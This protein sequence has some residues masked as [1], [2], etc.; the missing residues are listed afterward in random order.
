MFFEAVVLSV[1]IKTK[2]L[3]FVKAAT[4][5]EY[6]LS[7]A[8]LPS[9]SLKGGPLRFTLANIKTQIKI[10]LRAAVLLLGSQRGAEPVVVLITTIKTKPL[11]A[12]KA[13][14]MWG[15]R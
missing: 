10:Q 13:Q 4:N 2:V 12:A 15:E 14:Q 1:S 7:Y 5:A 6:C 9:N 11:H 8:S 3:H